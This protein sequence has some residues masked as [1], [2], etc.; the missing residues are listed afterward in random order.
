MSNI[1][2]LIYIF[3]WVFT[4]IR[5]FRKGYGAD[6]VFF[7]NVL[8]LSLGV[9]SFLLFNDKSIYGIEFK[10]LTLFPFLFL[11]FVLQLCIAPIR[12]YCDKNYV[13][14][15]N[16]NDRIIWCIAVFFI[17]TSLV[18]LP[19]NII[20]FQEG[21]MKIIFDM[22][23]GLDAY[24]DAALSS[25]SIED[26]SIKNIF[27]IFSAAF[28]EIG[29]FILFYYLTREK[30][31]IVMITALVVSV[32]GVIIDPISKG[33]RTVPM[34]ILLA[35][36]FAYLLFKPYLQEKINRVVKRIGLAIMLIL[37]VPLVSITI[38]RFSDSNSGALGSM[39]KY[40][41][42]ST[43]IFN[44]YAFDSGGVRYGDRTFPLFKKMMGFENVPNNYSQRR[45]KYS[46]MKMDDSHFITF[47]GDFILDYGPIAAFIILMIFTAIFGSLINC[48]SDCIPIYNLLFVYFLLNIIVQGSLYLFS[49][50][51]V[52]GNLKIITYSLIY[53]VLKLYGKK[54]KS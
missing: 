37:I 22:N 35:W 24:N 36:F 38:S 51:D 39:E 29:I 10:E 28:S 17:G 31:S 16:V 15:S 52:G 26:G 53:I 43:L 41:G 14:I 23:A 45:A 8:Y 21:V 44:N 3:L 19:S 25:D 12:S 4:I 40:L 1:Y 42:Q 33:N 50:A 18:Q 2:L 54:L 13:G 30:K 20:N 49:Y 7:V 47:V 48:R 32:L 11:F 34:L 27:Y 6:L 5:R 46:H 9:I